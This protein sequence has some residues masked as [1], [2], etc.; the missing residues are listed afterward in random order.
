M[1]RSPVTVRSSPRTSQ[2]GRG[3]NA[4]IACSRATSIAKVGVCTRPIE[5]SASPPA[6]RARAVTA[7]VAFSPTSQSAS[8]RER[9]ASASG[10][11]CRPGRSAANPRRIASSVSDEIHSRSTG[12]LPP[13]Y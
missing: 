3:T 6:P 12:V 1:N 9:A 4:R 11:S 10:S 13:A 5:Y 8:E 7:R 2:Y